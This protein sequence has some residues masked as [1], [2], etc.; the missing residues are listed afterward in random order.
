MLSV[1]V[2]HAPRRPAARQR[3]LPAALGRLTGGPFG[4]EIRLAA[5][6]ALDGRP[7]P[8]CTEP[9]LRFLDDRRTQYFWRG[10]AVRALARIEDEAAVQRVVAHFEEQRSSTHGRYRA[11]AAKLSV[12]SRPAGGPAGWSGN[13]GQLPDPGGPV[14]TAARHT[15][16]RRGPRRLRAQPLVAV[17]AAVVLDRPVPD[18]G[19]RGTGRTGRAR[20]A[21]GSRRMAHSTGP[22]PGSR[23]SSRTVKPKCS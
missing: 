22:P 1:P 13:P 19:P 11:E 21:R 4:E 15:A 6:R 18:S 7:E 12:S 14:S 2:G 23:S 16:G 10:L 9:L 8:G 5:V 17:E 3:E 20:Q